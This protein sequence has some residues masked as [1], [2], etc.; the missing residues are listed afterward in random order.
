M[1]ILDFI[2]GMVFMT[3]FGAFLV[4]Y[5]DSRFA[6]WYDKHCECSCKKCACHRPLEECE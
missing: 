1:A 2:T 6:R 5:R 3:L 4:F